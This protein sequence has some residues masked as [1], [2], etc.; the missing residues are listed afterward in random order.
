M[1]WFLQ[2]LGTYGIGI[3]TPTILAHTIGHEVTHAHNVSAIIARDLGY[4]PEDIN[5]GEL[6]RATEDNSRLAEGFD[7]ETSCCR[8]E[9]VCRLRGIL[10]GAKGQ[11]TAM[12]LGAV[13]LALLSGVALGALEYAAFKRA[14]P[15]PQEIAR[16]QKIFL[17]QTTLA[18]ATWA[19]GPCL[20]IAGA[21]GVELTLF[22]TILLAVCTVAMISVAEQR[23]AMLAFVGA[24]VAPPAI[25]LWRSGGAVQGTVALALVCGMVFVILV[26]LRFNQAVRELLENQGRNRAI[27][28]TALDAIIEINAQ[29]RITDWNRRA[30]TV[31]GW[32]KDE[33]LGLVLAETIIA[34]S[35]RA[36]VR[37][38]L[39]GA[40]VDGGTITT[41]TYY[42]VRIA[43][44]NEI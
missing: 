6:V 8:I 19:L 3:F 1:P 22:V 37:G 12:V 28:D 41:T 13:P 14:T 20:M 33:A 31:F 38:E 17:A 10:R 29:G 39:G 21:S 36:A 42:K 44:S 2:D 15:K 7:R 34:Q 23:M 40:T 9:S 27:L 26:G 4:A 25:V 11:T 5:V 18:G 32:R 43:S 30:E 35:H 16:W 24:A